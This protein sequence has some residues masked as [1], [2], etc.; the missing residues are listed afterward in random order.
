MG[1]AWI[2]MSD[3]FNPE[4]VAAVGVEMKRLSGYVAECKPQAGARGPA[5]R[6]CTS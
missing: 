2:D 5:A 3:A 6:L 1:V 4:S